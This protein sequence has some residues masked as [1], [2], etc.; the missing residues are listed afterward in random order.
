M[1]E[2]PPEC[3][4]CG[5]L[6]L[7]AVLGA[8]YERKAARRR[9]RG[10][11]LLLV[12]CA[13]L[14][15]WIG[16]LAANLPVRYESRQWRAAWVGFD[17]ALLCALAATAWYGWRRRQLLVPWAQAAAVLLLCDAWFDVLLSWGTRDL[18]AALLT[19]LLLELPLAALLL[20]RVRGILRTVLR[21][22]W[23]LARLPG[24]PPP[25]HRARLLVDPSPPGRSGPDRGTLDA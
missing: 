4:R 19:A 23:H 25:L 9:R 2:E 16:Y 12:C 22:Y 5:H 24:E 18:R 11:T 13:V 1:A 21:I 8:D 7:A 10:L 3:P 17:V 20:V 6:D 15:P 14:L